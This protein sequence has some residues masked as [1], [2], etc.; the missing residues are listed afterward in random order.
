MV[1]YIDFMFAFEP[2]RRRDF[3]ILIVALI[4]FAVFI[5]I[6]PPLDKHGL[7][8]MEIDYITWARNLSGYDLYIN[9][10]ANHHGLLSPLLIKLWLMLPVVKNIDFHTRLLSLIVFIILLFVMATVRIEGVD[11]R[12]RLLSIFFVSI[13]MMMVAFSRNAR[14]LP[15]FVLLIFL[16]AVFLYRNIIRMNPINASLLFISSLLSL[17][18]HPLSLIFLT[19][20]MLS[21]FIL[22]GLKKRTLLSVLPLL[23]AFVIYSFIFVDYLE[24]G[25]VEEELPPLGIN[26]IVSWIVLLLDDIDTIFIIVLILLMFKEINDCILK[27]KMIFRRD[28]VRYA[29][30][31][32]V[33]GLLL[34][35]AI[36]IFL[37]LTRRYYIIPLALFSS[38]LLA[39]IL[40][41]FKR[42][43]LIT[44]I[45]ILSIKSLLSFAVFDKTASTFPESYGVEKGV[46]QDLRNDEMYKGID[47]SKTIF[48]NLPIC[49]TRTFN[50]YRIS[51]EDIYPT[52]NRWG[53]TEELL[54]YEHMVKLS[55]TYNAVVI[56]WRSCEKIR[57]EEDR[58][59]CK[60]NMKILREI[61]GDPVK[62]KVKDA[63]DKTVKIMHFISNQR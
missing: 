5:R 21:T 29:L 1:W 37:P 18:N 48:I 14:L 43:T 4:L 58:K 23:L 61:Y 30:L 26:V 12:S 24:F 57:A 13:N 25:K 19:S 28:F 56:L 9:C 45:L 8:G 62:V 51:G 42:K 32:L 22:Y 63:G 2:D 35:I 50:Y 7:N 38:I 6:A 47:L 49:Q 3:L 53:Y 27:L 20:M 59:L 15:L 60:L 17:V 41:S 55:R 16:S 54:G 44:I 33:L 31:N 39:S 40:L 46:I 36:S 52:I 11:S 10:L 34:I